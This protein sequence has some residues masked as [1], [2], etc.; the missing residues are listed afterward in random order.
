VAAAD[1]GVEHVE[2]VALH[3]DIAIKADETGLALVVDTVSPAVTDLLV[4]PIV[5]EAEVFRIN[6]ELALRA[7]VPGIA[8]TLVLAD[9]GPP[10]VADV[11]VVGQQSTA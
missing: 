5:S 10:T 6:Y 4:G 11:V 8:L 9:A 3:H 2:S 7:L 1:S